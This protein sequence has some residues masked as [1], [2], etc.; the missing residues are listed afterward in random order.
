MLNAQAAGA[1]AVVIFNQGNTSD[2]EGLI[3]GRLDSPTATTIPVVGAT[4]ALGAEW[5]LSPVA[6]MRILVDALSGTLTTSNV[7]AELAGSQPTMIIAGAAL[8]S[9]AGS[10]GIN[11]NASG[12]AALLETAVQMARVRPRNTVRFAWW[13]S[14]DPFG[15]A[16]HVAGL[17]PEELAATALYLNFDVIASPNYV[18][19]VY[20]GDGSASGLPGPDGSAAIES[21]IGSFYA[22]RGLAVEPQSLAILT[23]HLPFASVGI[24]VGGIHSGAIGIKTP[25]EAAVYGGV[26]GVAYD[27]CYGL[28]C[29]TFANVNADLLDLN[30]DIVASSVVTF[31]MSVAAV[32][33]RPGRGNSPSH[34]LAAG[35]TTVDR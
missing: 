25:A 29:D 35:T 33:G 16:Q 13:A 23:D 32:N 21:V 4:Y 11:A 2:R 3:G 5:F 7:I 24:P 34:A 20:D 10:P 1:V 27:P 8:G 28:A 15:A 12:A 26:A 31:G 9:L 6:T 30:A 19:F 22:A 14:G 18:R 17:T